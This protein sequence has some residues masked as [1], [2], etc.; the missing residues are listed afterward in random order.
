MINVTALNAWDPEM[1][2]AWYAAYHEGNAAGRHAPL[3]F[4]APV[5]LD[6]LT[7]ES[8]SIRRPFGV[9]EGGLCLGAAMLDW[10]PEQNAHLGNIEVCVP[11]AHRRSGI[12]TALLERLSREANNAGLTTLMAAVYTADSGSRD[13]E[14]ARQAGFATVHTEDHMVMDLPAPQE[15]LDGWVSSSA[16]PVLGYTSHSWQ[17]PTPADRQEKMAALQSAMNIDVPSGEMDFDPFMVTVQELAEMDARMARRGYITFTTV[18]SAPTGEPVG[19]SRVFTQAEAQHHVMQ[20]DTWVHSAHRGHRIAAWLKAENIALVQSMV[21]QARFLHTFNAQT[22]VAIQ[23][24]NRRFGFRRTEV[25]H[26]VQ[27]G[28]RPSPTSPDQ[29]S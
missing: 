17:G 6:R 28:G 27:R 4:P 29:P 18:A 3:I 7:K 20:D 22:N 25:L 10:D 26:E 11:P 5:V 23:T 19:Y 1:F 21:P 24:L 13:L 16:A 8:R 12:G 9:F 2:T 15:T 14:F